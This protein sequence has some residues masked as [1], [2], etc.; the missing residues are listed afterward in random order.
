[1][2]ALIKSGLDF[3]FLQVEIG[4]IFVLNYVVV[5]KIKNTV[6]LG[7][8]KLLP[9]LDLKVLESFLVQWGLVLGL[10]VGRIHCRVVFRALSPISRGCLRY[11]SPDHIDSPVG[12]RIGWSSI[13]FGFTKEVQ[14]KN[15]L[16]GP[17]SVFVV[18]VILNTDG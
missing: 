16:A 1:M 3:I 18:I 9:M 8:S 10:T 15:L 6:V 5:F 12:A 11:T 7:G 4:R 2:I 17:G 14:I 13:P